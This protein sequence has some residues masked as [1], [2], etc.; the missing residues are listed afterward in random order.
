MRLIRTTLPTI[1]VLASVGALVS[2]VVIS[3]VEARHHHKSTTQS[4]AANPYA[5][6]LA[7]R[8]AA[9]LNVMPLPQGVT[10]SPTVCM[11]PPTRFDAC[12]TGTLGAPAADV[13][14]A[15]TDAQQFLSSLGVTFD[16]PVGCSPQ[17]GGPWGS[18]FGCITTGS[19]H[20]APIAMAVFVSNETH[21]AKGTPS[22]AAMLSVRVS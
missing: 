13:S 1:A 15:T 17:T 9:A 16:H 5:D 10:H 3:T 18:G 8:M 21:R 12:F 20:T 19:W 6:Q 22:L 14:A 7:A 2:G 11:S 4:V